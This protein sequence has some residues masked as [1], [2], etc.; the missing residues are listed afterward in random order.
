[1]RNI[2]SVLAEMV[3]NCA[4]SEGKIRCPLISSLQ[5]Q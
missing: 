5:Q 2:E 4:V 1:L 3:R